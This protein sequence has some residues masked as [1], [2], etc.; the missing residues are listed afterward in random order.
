[1]NGTSVGPKPH[2]DADASL[3]Q[4]P[5]AADAPELPDGLEPDHHDPDSFSVRCTNCGHLDTF[6]ARARAHRKANSHGLDCAPTGVTPV[7]EPEVAADGG[8][9]VLD[10]DTERCYCGRFVSFVKYEKGAY[11]YECEKH[12][13]ITWEDLSSSQIHTSRAGGQNE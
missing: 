1:M 6:D 5:T 8:S 7:S 2:N 13:H 12:G 11:V 4:K 3:G 10:S 9:E